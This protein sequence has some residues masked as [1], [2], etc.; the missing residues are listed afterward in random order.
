MDVRKQTHP[1]AL[2]YWINNQATYGYL[3]EMALD[4]L[5]APASQAYVER[6]FSVCGMLCQGR[7][8]RMSRSLEMRVK[9]KLNFKKY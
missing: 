4:I 8:N 9:Q 1:N 6:I 3:A 5:A 7:R 2:T